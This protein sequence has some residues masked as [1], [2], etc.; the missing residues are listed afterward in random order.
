MQEQEEVVPEEDQ[1]AA[2]AEVR[3]A[4]PEVIIMEVTEKV[5]IRSMR[6]SGLGCWSV[7][8][9]AERLYS[10]M[11]FAI[12]KMPKDINFS[13]TRDKGNRML[14]CCV[15]DPLRVGI[16]ML[17]TDYPPVLNRERSHVLGLLI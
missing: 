12:I 1:E 8:P 4:V 5:V 3:E 11:K 10:I 17:F 13:Y 16:L 9:G 6:G 7:W 15:E 14:N 2:L